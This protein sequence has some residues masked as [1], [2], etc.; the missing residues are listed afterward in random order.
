MT[1]I[2]RLRA[3]LVAVERVIEA[4]DEARELQPDDEMKWGEADARRWRSNITARLAQ[5]ERE[6]MGNAPRERP[7]VA[8]TLDGV[9]CNSGGAK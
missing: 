1:R 6:A 4:L 9:V 7:A 8:G 5:A 3:Q 2:N